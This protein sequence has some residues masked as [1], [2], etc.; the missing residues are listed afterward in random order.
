MGSEL[1]LIQCLPQAVFGSGIRK[2]TEG[3]IYFTHAEQGVL[4]KDSAPAQGEVQYSRH[5]RSLK[6]GLKAHGL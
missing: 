6:D 4:G 5:K 2:H 1:C 3:G